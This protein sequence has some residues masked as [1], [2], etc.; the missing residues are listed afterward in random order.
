MDGGL[1]LEGQEVYFKELLELVKQEIS[2]YTRYA[3]RLREDGGIRHIY[4]T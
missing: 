2:L 1:V 4:Q 3:V